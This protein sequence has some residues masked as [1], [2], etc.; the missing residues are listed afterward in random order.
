[1]GSNKESDLLCLMN[2]YSTIHTKSISR[3]RPVTSKY[4]TA[5]T[6]GVS[7]ARSSID[8]TTLASTSPTLEARFSE[9]VARSTTTPGSA[10]AS[11]LLFD[12]STAV[13]HGTTR[14]VKST[15]AR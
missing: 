12:W 14:T 3:L 9:V 10:A 7:R 8:P 5:S 2:E 4:E 6:I 13:S 15:L 1:M 11:P